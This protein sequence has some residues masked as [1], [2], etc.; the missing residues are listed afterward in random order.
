MQ[1]ETKRDYISLNVSD[2]SRKIIYPV[3]KTLLQ[4]C[5]QENAF[6]FS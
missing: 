6:I 4:Y 2:A 1:N 5:K 3:I